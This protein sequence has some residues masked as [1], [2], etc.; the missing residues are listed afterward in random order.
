[1]IDSQTLWDQLATLAEVL[2]PTYEHSGAT[3]SRP[4]WWARMRR[5]DN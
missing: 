3:S 2:R 4:R 5:G 1:M